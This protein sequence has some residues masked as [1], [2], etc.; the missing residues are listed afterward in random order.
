MTVCREITRLICVMSLVFVLVTTRNVHAQNDERMTRLYDARDLAPG[1]PV[2]PGQDPSSALGSLFITIAAQTGAAAQSPVAGLFV[3]T[4]N[5][6]Q[7]RTLTSLL[8]SLRVSMLP[9]YD[10][11]LVMFQTETKSAPEQG[12]ELSAMPADAQLI[13]S[14]VHRRVESRFELRRNVAYVAEFSPVV[15]SSSVSYQ[16]V[17]KTMECGAIVDIVVGLGDDRPTTSSDGGNPNSSAPSIPF[18]LNVQISTGQIDH[19]EVVLVAMQNDRTLIGLPSIDQ[20]E[21]EV[22]TSVKPDT[23]TVVASVPKS[24]SAALSLAVRIRPRP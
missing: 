6:T 12:S 21:L 3:V 24:E 14:T 8:E 19:E 11:E 15:A 1:I 22:S 4:G 13:R 10:I 7:H 16:P 9:R 5:E 17:T 18:R 23:L 20:R 2:S